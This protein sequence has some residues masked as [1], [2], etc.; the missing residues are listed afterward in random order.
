LNFGKLWESLSNPVFQ[1]LY[2]EDHCESCNPLR[3]ACLPSFYLGCTLQKVVL[4][5]TSFQQFFYRF[6]IAPAAS[7]HTFAQR[8]F[9]LPL[10]PLAS[11]PD[12]CYIPP[13]KQHDPHLSNTQDVAR[14]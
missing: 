3:V 10:T 5:I 12:L 6:S 2:V 7:T 13:I 11:S 1:L 4:P 8:F 9:A 14:G